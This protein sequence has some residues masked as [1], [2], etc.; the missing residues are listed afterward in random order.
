MI[1]HIHE[2]IKAERNIFLPISSC[3]GSIC[4]CHTESWLAGSVDNQFDLDLLSSTAELSSKMSS[5]DMSTEQLFGGWV[6]L[7]WDTTYQYS[8]LADGRSND[9]FAT[10]LLPWWFNPHCVRVTATWSLPTSQNW[11]SRG[12]SS[13]FHIEHWRKFIKSANCGYGIIVI[14]FLITFATSKWTL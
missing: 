6:F 7:K 2:N 5:L 9:H 13:S 4:S 14:F 11:P 1:L 12:L 3:P 10:H 8:I